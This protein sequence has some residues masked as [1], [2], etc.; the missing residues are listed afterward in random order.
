MSSDLFD[1]GYRATQYDV[2]EGYDNPSS[3]DADKLVKKSK[4]NNK[5]KNLSSN[6]EKIQDNLDDLQTPYHGLGELL[7]QKQTTKIENTINKNKVLET[8]SDIYVDLYDDLKDLAYHTI[9]KLPH[10]IKNTLIKEKHAHKLI[11][12]IKHNLHAIKG[13]Y[14]DLKHHNMD[15]LTKFIELILEVVHWLFKHQHFTFHYIP[16][17]SGSHHHHIMNP[18]ILSTLNLSHGRFTERHHHHHHRHH[19]NHDVNMYGRDIPIMRFLTYGFPKMTKILKNYYNSF[20]NFSRY[21]T[22]L[23]RSGTSFSDLITLFNYKISDD[24]YDDKKYDIYSLGSGKTLDKLYPKDYLIKHRG[25]LSGYYRWCFQLRIYMIKSHYCLEINRLA[26]GVMRSEYILTRYN[27]T[28]LKNYLTSVFNIVDVIIDNFINNENLKNTH[29]YTAKQIM[30][31]LPFQSIIYTQC[32]NS[33]FKDCCSALK[34][35]NPSTGD[36]LLKCTKKSDLTNLANLVDLETNKYGLDQFYESFFVYNIAV[37]NYALCTFLRDRY[38]HNVNARHTTPSVSTQSTTDSVLAKFLKRFAIKAHSNVV[39]KLNV[40]SSPTTTTSTTAEGFQNVNDS[41][42]SEDEYV[43]EGFRWRRKKKK[44]HSSSTS[45]SKSSSTTTTKKKTVVKPRFI[46]SNIGLGTNNVKFNAGVSDI[47]ESSNVS[48]NGSTMSLKEYTEEVLDASS[49]TP[50]N[51]PY[52]SASYKCGNVS[53]NVINKKSISDYVTFDCSSGTTDDKYKC[54][55]FRLELMD[56]GKV[57]IMKEGNKN[58]IYWSWK[59]NISTSTANTIIQNYWS[60]SSHKNYLDAGNTLENA[61]YLVSKNKTFQ[62]VNNKGSLRL[63]YVTRPCLIDEKGEYFGYTDTSDGKKGIGLYFMNHANAKHIGK[64]GYIDQDGKMNLYKKND[65]GFVDEYL[66]VGNFSLS[67]NSNIKGTASI[68]N[69]IL[70]DKDGNEIF[71]TDG[72]TEACETKCNL[73]DDCGGFTYKDGICRLK[74]GNMFPK[75]LRKVDTNTQMYVRMRGAKDS[76]LDSSCPVFEQDSNVPNSLVDDFMTSRSM[77]SKNRSAGDACN[78][79]NLATPYLKFYEK[80]KVKYKAAEKELLDA[81]KRLS[82]EEKKQVR[83]FKM[84]IKNMETDINE[85]DKIYKDLAKEYESQDTITTSLNESK[86]YMNQK[87]VEIASYGVIALATVFIA[88]SLIKN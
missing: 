2:I 27:Y 20:K 11:H 78:M 55:T 60:N 18:K 7:Y 62:L 56:D 15:K 22:E 73:Y 41:E 40:G 45:S 44:K 31:F 39:T 4:K 35:L 36:Y 43:Q 1:I 57:V 72:D 64:S 66:P 63:Y 58:K 8:S 53:A 24:A 28:M 5:S 85:Y 86:D 46:T 87:S 83:K 80:S 14:D 26:V 76:L 51:T 12:R 67:E 75:G 50:T 47:L 17:Y 52:F 21:T 59:P 10:Q 71:V 9:H 6:N 84:N 25:I 49:C 61:D 70:T 79:K 69:T 3:I 74:N 34:K 29:Q 42:D 82:T 33:D 19:H 30:S 32:F 88:M 65:I 23:D 77:G 13:N 38:C 37:L 81:L 68:N 16:G 48:V 54:N